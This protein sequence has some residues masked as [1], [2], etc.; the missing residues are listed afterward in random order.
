MLKIQNNGSVKKG[1]FSK[2]VLNVQKHVPFLNDCSKVQ[3]MFVFLEGSCF[4]F[5]VNFK[6]TL[7]VSIFFWLFAKLNE[8]FYKLFIYLK[9]VWDFK[10]CSHFQVY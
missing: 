10:M 9:I 7:S 8:T 2:I 5:S 6:N 1:H 4:H 3:K